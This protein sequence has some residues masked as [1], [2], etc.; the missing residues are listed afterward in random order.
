MSTGTKQAILFVAMIVF[1]IG[2]AFVL[3]NVLG[4]K[5]LDI[6]GRYD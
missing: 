2:V 3:Y 4:L 5:V 1:W 6:N